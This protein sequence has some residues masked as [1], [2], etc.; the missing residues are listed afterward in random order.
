ML[1]SFLL[2][3][4]SVIPVIVPLRAQLGDWVPSSYVQVAEVPLA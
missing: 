2:L 4:L 3:P 1:Q